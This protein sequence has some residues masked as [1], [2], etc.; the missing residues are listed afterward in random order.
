MGLFGFGKSKEE[1]KEMDDHLELAAEVGKEE[2]DRILIEK[3]KCHY[4]PHLLYF[5][6]S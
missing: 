5:H 3:T 6:R 2:F 4:F 1:K